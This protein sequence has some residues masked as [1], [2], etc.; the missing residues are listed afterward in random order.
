MSIPAI[1]R[2]EDASAE[3]LGIFP[4]CGKCMGLCTELRISG[5]DP[6]TSSRGSSKFVEDQGQNIHSIN[7]P[8][9]KA[10]EAPERR[11]NETVPGVVGS[12]FSVVGCP[13]ARDNPSFG[14]LNAF[15]PAPCAHTSE[16]RDAAKGRI[17][18]CMAENMGA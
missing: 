16:R 12:Q 3:R 14:I 17:M 2:E 9:S 4:D 18:N 13:A 11:N 8:W 1:K 10:L 6:I 7:V 5:R 15:G